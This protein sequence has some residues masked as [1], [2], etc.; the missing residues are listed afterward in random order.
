MGHYNSKPGLIGLFLAA[1]CAINSL[2]NKDADRVIGVGDWKFPQGKLGIER[3][4]E[5]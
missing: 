5:C 4:M 2:K 1:F 3:H